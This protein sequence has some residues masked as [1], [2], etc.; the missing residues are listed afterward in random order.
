M[1]PEVEVQF[2]QCSV[3]EVKAALMGIHIADIAAPFSDMLC[4]YGLEPENSLDWI[5]A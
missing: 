5:I 4:A 3:S 1:A 2:L